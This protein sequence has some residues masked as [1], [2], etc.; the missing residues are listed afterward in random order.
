M[1]HVSGAAPRR[2]ATCAR[3]WRHAGRVS[4]DRRFVSTRGASRAWC[5]SLTSQ[6]EDGIEFHGAADGGGAAGES[7]EDGDGEDDGKQYWLDRDLRTENRAA[8]PVGK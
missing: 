2:A 4:A 6:S 1:R 7:Y 3:T 5:S 8:D